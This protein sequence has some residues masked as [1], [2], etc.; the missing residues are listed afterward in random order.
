M[1]NLDKELELRVIAMTSVYKG[2]ALGISSPVGQNMADYS[3][4]VGN[5]MVDAAIKKTLRVE[6]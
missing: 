5:D 3:I 6:E 2:I 1:I 4:S